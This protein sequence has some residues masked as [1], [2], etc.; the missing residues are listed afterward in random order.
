MDTLSLTDLS[1]FIHHEGE[2]FSNY[3]YVS[4]LA[5]RSYKKSPLLRRWCCVRRDE[6]RRKI[7]ME[8]FINQHDIEP[9][10][11]ISLS[12]A[13]LVISRGA[14][15]TRA[16]FARIDRDLGPSSPTVQSDSHLSAFYIDF[17]KKILKDI[18]SRDNTIYETRS[19]KVADNG[20][21]DFPL[22]FIMVCPSDTDAASLLESALSQGCHVTIPRE[23]KRLKVQRWMNRAWMK[24]RG[25]LSIDQ[26][27]ETSFNERRSN[28][29]GEM[30]FT[31]APAA[32][33]RDQVP[34]IDSLDLW[35]NDAGSGSSSFMTAGDDDENS[36]DDEID[37]LA[38]DGFQK[39]IGKLPHISDTEFNSIEEMLMEKSDQVRHAT[40]IS[41]N[42]ILSVIEYVEAT[43]TFSSSSLSNG[44]SL[45]SEGE[46]FDC[47]KSIDEST[48]IV[49]TRTWAKLPN[50]PPQTLFHI[51]Y[52]CEA[53]KSW[54]HHYS[55]FVS[56][57]SDNDQLD[58]IDAVV[59]APFGCA[60]REF[61][62]WRRKN[63]PARNRTDRTGNFVIYL[64]SF[65][66]NRPVGKNNVRA[67]VWLSG[68]LIQWW[69]SPEGEPLGSQVLVMTQ[70][71]VKGLIPKYLVNALS[72][73]GPKRWVKSVTAAAISEIENTRKIALDDILKKSDIELDQLYSIND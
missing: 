28:T 68:Y 45:C 8:F 60:S 57:W 47:F 40:R 31:I 30:F 13:R 41:K 61:L 5:M 32:Q 73:S 63:V 14:K 51:L 34:R 23:R 33:R 35:E 27:D 49:R 58:I 21:D 18:V 62:E 48:G 4:S 22:G 7:Y 1:Q 66:D 43:K 29:D 39:P 72:S 6:D 44:W 65:D 2:L 12:C 15:L 20:Q 54:D 17:P 56:E 46:N 64:R 38:F 70:I 55:R 3:V 16:Q 67:E 19:V 24:L 25:E 42:E 9:T 10:K 50:V 71:D 11:R 69:M 53:R 59:S 37:R 36:Q 26:F 52:N